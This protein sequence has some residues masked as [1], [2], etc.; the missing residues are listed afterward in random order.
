MAIDQ[1][2]LAQA[3]REQRPIV[4]IYRWQEPTLTLG[5]FQ[6]YAA[7]EKHAESLPLAV[8][9]RA[10]GGGA[11]VHHHDWTY[12]ICVP[13]SLL[14][15]NIGASKP[16]YD[17]LH[18]AAIKWLSN[19]G[20]EAKQFDAKTCSSNSAAECRFLCF[21]R[22]SEGDLVVGDTKVLGSAQRR[23]YDSLLQHGSLLLSKSDFAPSLNGLFELGLS[24]LGGLVSTSS[25]QAQSE[26]QTKHQDSMGQFAGEISS[27][28]REFA[29]AIGAAVEEFFDLKL[30]KTDNLGEILTQPI[31][32]ERFLEKKW[33]HRR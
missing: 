28:Y 29:D 27:M 7:R 14:S 15:S 21:E 8:V 24:K 23:K 31:E 1:A 6:E 5:Y 3:S 18:G 17:T 25:K 30:D 2:L 20:I 32:S 16:V 19:Y 33:L 11:I 9:R 12:S 10:S 4:R 26:T 13:S 22:R